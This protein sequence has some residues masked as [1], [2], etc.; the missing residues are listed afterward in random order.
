MDPSL[1]T[2]PGDCALAM[3]VPYTRDQ[4][5]AQLEPE[6]PREFAKWYARMNGGSQI[7]NES[8]WSVFERR[9]ARAIARLLEECEA[10]GVAVSRE[11]TLGAF[12]DLARRHAVVVVVAHWRTGRFELAST[13]LYVA[14]GWMV[15]I[16]Y[17]PMT[18]ALPP[19]TLAWLLVGG[20]SYTGGTVFYLNRRM[21]YAH[22]IWHLFVLGGSACHFAA[23]LREVVA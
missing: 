16:A 19:A 9:E 21:P 12:G 17:R 8:L 18:A 7:A 13:L 15:L 5:L 2:R 3:A 23:V 20:L 6:S 14:L 10:L 11:C 22:G 1:V 4:F